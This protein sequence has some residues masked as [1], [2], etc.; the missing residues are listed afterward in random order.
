MRFARQLFIALLFALVASCKEPYDF[1]TAPFIDGIVIDGL[2]D[3]GP[4]PWFVNIGTTVAAE[5]KQKPLQG[6]SVKITDQDRSFEYLREVSPGRYQLD[7]FIVRGNP[8]NSYTLDVT[9][10][11][12][13]HYKSTSETMP[14]GSSASDSVYFDVSTRKMVSSENVEI[15]VWYVNIRLNTLLS[16]AKDARYR[17]GI[18]E[19]Y[20]VYPTCWPGSISCPKI[21]YVYQPTSRFNIAL[22]DPSQLIDPKINNLLLQERSVD[23]SFNGRHYFNVTQYVMNPETYQYWKRVQEIVVK[24]GSIFDTPPARIRGNISNE[25]NPS[26]YAFGYFEASRTR[27]SRVRVDRGYIPIQLPS[28]DYNAQIPSNSN[29]CYDCTILEGSTL[30]EPDWF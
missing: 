16:E 19:V 30:I 24:K 23:E 1:A 25:D 13:N 7:G 28:C 15:N 29:Y 8:G 4:G 2:I 27:V 11:N 22:A 21:C 20:S 6:A 26:D 12:G 17:W 3:D 10:P 9:L 5:R 18:D 14:T